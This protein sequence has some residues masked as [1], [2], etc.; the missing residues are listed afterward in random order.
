MTLAESNRERFLSAFAEFAAGNA[1]VLNQVIRE[2]FIEHSPNTPSG[3]D[4]YIA[5][6]K[7]SGVMDSRLDLKRV[8]ADDEYVVAHY[9]VTGPGAETGLAVVDIWRFDNG[10]IV[11][12]W[13]V[14]Q[15]VPDSSEVPNGML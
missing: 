10:Q 11:E 8:I 9:L 1:D 12:H 3:R 13:D 4:A 7:T 5:H 15:P 6:L 14:A 2:D